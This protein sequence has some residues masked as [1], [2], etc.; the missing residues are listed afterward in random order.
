M[1]SFARF[2]NSQGQKAVWLA[3]EAITEVGYLHEH[4]QMQE[5][6]MRRGLQAHNEDELLQIVDLA[7]AHPNSDAIPAYVSF[8]RVQLSAGLEMQDAKARAMDPSN[9]AFETLFQDLRAGLLKACYNR[10]IK[11]AANVASLSKNQW[12]PEIPP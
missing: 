3:L 6:Y 9:T 5:I 7:I 10:D 12:S 4:P 11:D 1:D 2:R 8:L